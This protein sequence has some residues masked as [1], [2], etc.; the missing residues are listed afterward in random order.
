LENT[1]GNYR[2]GRCKTRITTAQDKHK[3]KG[4]KY[5]ES[6]ALKRSVTN[7]PLGVNRF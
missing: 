4:Y 1:L 2:N 6:T 3:S 5:K 7:S